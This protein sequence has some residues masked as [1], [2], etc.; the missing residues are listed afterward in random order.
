M[1]TGRWAAWIVLFQLRYIDMSIRHPSGEGAG[2]DVRTWTSGEGQRWRQTFG[3]LNLD[4]WILL[5]VPYLD[6]F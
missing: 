1:T 5:K 2:A 6:K 4:V 3:N